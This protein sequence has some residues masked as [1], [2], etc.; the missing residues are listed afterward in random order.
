M[1]SRIFAS[2]PCGVAL[3][4]TVWFGM[5]H[6]VAF[7]QRDGVAIERVTPA[8]FN[9]KT[10]IQVK[11][12]FDEKRGKLDLEATKKLLKQP[13]AEEIELPSPSTQ[14]RTATDI[15]QLARA[16][17]ARICFIQIDEMNNLR[18]N[19][20]GA[21]AISANGIFA[22]C[23]HCLNPEGEQPAGQWWLMLI[24]AEGDVHPVSSILGANEQLDAAI[25]K[26]E[27][28]KTEPLPFNDQVSPGDS[29]YCYSEPMSIQ[30]YFSDGIVNRFYWL[31]NQERNPFELD[32]A[33]FCR[34]NF[35]TDWAPGSS[36]AS[37]VDQYGN[38]I[39]HVSKITAL[40]PPQPPIQQP[41]SPEA[42]QAAAQ[43]PETQEQVRPGQSHGP[44]PP[45]I[46]GGGAT[47]MV[48]HEGI[49]ARGVKLLAE[50]VNEECRRFPPEPDMPEE[51][52][53]TTVETSQEVSAPA[54]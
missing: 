22:T 26:V 18:F 30:S 13:K 20:G 16:A 14:Q 50:K 39:G 54:N 9:Q 34:V 27:G 45:M 25:F 6:S 36:G 28:L 8:L 21:Y 35:S 33:A 43:N 52:D 49:P 3:A 17:Y 12:F 41:S 5:S 24:T 29:A 51:V 2:R 47:F 53:M 37:I 1:S 44:K 46:G 40:G 19:S 15:Y 32:D 4:L 11:Q 7:A 42:P 38:S 48:L 23:H 31:D 10:I